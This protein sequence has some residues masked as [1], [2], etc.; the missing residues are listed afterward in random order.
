M[1]IDDGPLILAMNRCADSKR[2]RKCTKTNQIN[3]MKKNFGVVLIHGAGLGNYIW[4]KITPLLEYPYLTVN[5]P[6]RNGKTIRSLTLDDYF[7]H[8][9]K[10]IDEWDKKELVIVAHSIGGIIG[11]KVAEHV[12][13]RMKGFIGISSVIPSKRGSFLSCFPLPKRMFMSLMI[14]TVGT[15]P[16]DSAI[17]HSLCNDLS[18][19]DTKKVIDNFI[20]E[21]KYLYLDKSNVAAINFPS[22]YIRT[23]KDNE[24]PLSL[25]D[26]MIRNLSSP[27]ITTLESGHLPMLSVPK[28]FTTEL[29][30]FIQT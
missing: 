1:T 17:K 21:S 6:G 8:V 5:F 19:D 2:R 16:P 9:I 10:Q 27:V 26:N 13:Q 23:S 22:L 20:P 14:R 25:Q 11:L 24:F 7:K 4:E 3:Y 28:E 18:Q 30:N 12:A 29:N 15:K